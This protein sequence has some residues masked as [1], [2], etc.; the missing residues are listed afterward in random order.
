MATPEQATPAAVE[1][2]ETPRIALA[3]LAAMA[4]QTHVDIT[5]ADAARAHS[6]YAGSEQ[7]CGVTVLPDG[8]ADSEPRYAVALYLTAAPTDLPALATEIATGVREAAAA[9]GLD[10]AISAIHI[11]FTDLTLPEPKRTAHA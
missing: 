10:G 1:R 6:T 11:T 3:R 8:T 9:D 5:G 2:R 7:L 4:A